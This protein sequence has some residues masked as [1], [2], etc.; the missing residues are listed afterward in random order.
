MSVDALQST[1]LFDAHGFD[2]HGAARNRWS[3]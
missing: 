2:A 1:D 3:S